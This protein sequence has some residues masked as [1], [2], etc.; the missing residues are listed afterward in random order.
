MT[1]WASTTGTWGLSANGKAPLYSPAGAII[2]EVSA[3]IL[4]RRVNASLSDS[5]PTLEVSSVLA[6]GFG[7]LASL[8][9]S[10]RLKKDTFG[11][12]L[13]EIASLLREREAMLHGIKEGIVTLTRDGR[14]S[15]INEEARR[16]LGVGGTAL[17]R[18]V[19][20]LLP[21]GPV[22]DV[23]TGAR[24]EVVDETV[25]TAD[26]ALVMTRMPVTH[27][28]A[29]LG[30]VVTA[31][32][33]TEM[34]GLIRELDSVRS[35]TDALRA[36]QHEHANRMHVLAGLLEL[37]RY[38]DATS[39]L[40]EISGAAADAAETLRDRI[41][42]P[43]V[44]ALLVAKTTIASERGVRLRV[45]I[46][47]GPGPVVAEDGRSDTKT[48]VTVVGNL[49][50]NAIDAAASSGPAGEVTVRLGRAPEGYL[51]IEVADSGPGV[52]DPDQIFR[53]G[54]STKPDRSGLGRGL[55]LALVQGLVNRAG[56]R[57][58]VRNDGGAVFRV[59]L[60]EAPRPVP[61]R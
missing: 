11:L 49:V 8:L 19:S 5:L 61:S 2:G 58:S 22:R 44:V 40:Q 51:S 18:P 56:G 4:E 20:E 28:G 21:P 42:H 29:L 39:Y 15:L 25:L 38:D 31:R 36:Q 57:I 27:A 9:I 23:L 14:I 43:A 47:P 32:D 35:L 52:A 26:Y 50:D 45:S 46:E 48:L 1:T 3:G 12:E 60:P 59:V 6:L 37:G 33:R 54:Y 13:H 34:L 10:R 53:D 41:G 55:G 17:N 30:A 16:L 24:G 7:A